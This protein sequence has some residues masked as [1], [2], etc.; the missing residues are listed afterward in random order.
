MPRPAASR[1]R[2]ER[3]ST[4]HVVERR[5][6]DVAPLAGHPL[7]CRGVVRLIVAL[8]AVR[9]PREVVMEAMPLPVWIPDC[10]LPW[11]PPAI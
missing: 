5:S 7:A 4:R 8:R 10:A 1:G 11:V 3:F 6:A 2:G 9:S